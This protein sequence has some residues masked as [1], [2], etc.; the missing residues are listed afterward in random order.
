MK[1]TLEEMG[2]LSA[3]GNSIHWNV[4]TSKLS[5]DIMNEGIVL[6]RNL[7]S[8]ASTS[9]SSYGDKGDHG[10]LLVI[11]ITD[12]GKTTKVESNDR[13]PKDFASLRKWILQYGRRSSGVARG[14]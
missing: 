9:P 6:A 12:E 8:N 13:M 7:I 10:M 14:D 5:A 2:G 3:A 1:I 4:D 11:K